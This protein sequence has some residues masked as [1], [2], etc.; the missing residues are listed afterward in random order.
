M[1]KRMI[2]NGVDYGDLYLVSDDGE[3]KGIK[4]GKIRKKNINH[5][6][7][8]FVSISTGSR[9]SGKCIKV[10]KAVAEAFIDNPNKLPQVNHKDGNKLNNT[11]NNLEW[12]TAQGNVRHA[13]DNHLIKNT[14]RKGK[15][16]LCVE[17]NIV[18]KSLHEA[19]R[20]YAIYTTNAEQ[21]RK[22]I[23]SA[24]RTNGRSFGKHWVY[25]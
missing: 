14:E 6:G 19:G 4:S 23:L 2:Y 21:A 1:W 7:Y 5:E 12:I 3:I 17:D 8:Y 16:V 18:Y 11:K 15:N 25:V 9:K 13:Y 22:N 24:V 20:V 10:H